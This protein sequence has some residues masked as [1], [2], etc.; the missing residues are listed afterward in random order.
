[1]VFASLPFLFVILPL[2]LLGDSLARYCNNARARNAVLLGLSCLF[3]VWGE[4]FNVLYLLAIGGITLIGGTLVHKLSCKKILLTI[5]ISVNLLFLFYFKYRGWL[6][7]LILPDIKPPQALMPLGISFFTFHAISYLIDIYRKEILP[8]KSILEFFTYFCMFPHLVAG[9]IVRYGQV[10][11]ALHERYSGYNFFAYGVYRFLVGLNKKVLIADSL[12]LMV[13]SAFRIEALNHLHFFD[14]WLGMTAYALQIYFD[15][16]GYSD[17]AI[18]LAAMAGIRFEEN[19]KRPYSSCSIRDFWRRW[20]IS[21]SSWFRDYVYF[22]LGG[23]RR[24]LFGT[25]CNLVIIFFLCGLWHGAEL[26][27]IVWGLWHGLALVLERLFFPAK[28]LN[29]VVGRVYVFF[30]VTVGWVFFR[31]ANMDEALRMLLIMFSPDMFPVTLTYHVKATLALGV[32]ACLI[33]LPDRF[34]PDYAK[35]SIAD[36][37]LYSIIPQFALAWLS[38]IILVSSETTPFLYF[39]F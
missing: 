10:E 34:L 15:F 4:N 32:G 2:F 25:L 23:N 13:D 7:S 21:L 39:N 27:F 29:Q 24:G 3:Y 14:A 19:F 38:V 16:S 11:N 35:T 1:M 37:S 12:S 28:P 5:F 8:A 26:S 20:H 33:L 17:M 31:A 22:P 9:P 36:I 6:F 18:G 30:W